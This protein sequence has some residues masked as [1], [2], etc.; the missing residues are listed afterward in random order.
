MGNRA[1]WTSRRK[2]CAVLVCA[3]MTV[4]LIAC[5]DWWPDPCP[6]GCPYGGICLSSGCFSCT[7]PQ[8]PCGGDYTAYCAD[9]QTDPK[10]C[11]ACGKTCGDCACVN[12][13]CASP[14]PGV[15]SCPNLGCVDPRTNT[16]HCGA[17]ECDGHSGRTCNPLYGTGCI[18]G[19]C[20]CA[21][22]TIRCDYDPGGGN[23]GWVY[24]CKP[25]QKCGGG[26][27]TY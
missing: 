3:L 4:A 8:Q 7:A 1:R 18:D 6:N 5:G 13:S 22:D 15:L 16:G 11:G 2:S 25:P 19:V 17:T 20:Q 9:F 27:C 24:C 12:G 23:A 26:S 14:G 10:N 21:A